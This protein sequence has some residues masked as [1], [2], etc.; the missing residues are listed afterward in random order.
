MIVGEKKYSYDMEALLGF[1]SQSPEPRTEVKILLVKPDGKRMA[2][3]S[4]C[5]LSG[6]SPRTMKYLITF[7]PCSGGEYKLQS[8]LSYNLLR[9]PVKGFVEGQVDISAPQIQP[10]K[11]EFQSDVDVEGSEKKIQSN[12]RGTYFF[13]FPEYKV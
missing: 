6:S 5:H 8:Q 12:V 1:M 9:V 10:V 7:E 4:N 13:D 11:V 2:L 3:V